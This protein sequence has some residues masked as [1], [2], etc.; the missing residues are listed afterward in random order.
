MLIHKKT[1]KGKDK[2]LRYKHTYS[3]TLILH[4]TVITL[5]GGTIRKFHVTIIVATC[6]LK[7]KS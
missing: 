2:Y 1:F 7:K 3:N 5:K 6:I 4:K